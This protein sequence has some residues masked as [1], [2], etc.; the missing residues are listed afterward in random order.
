MTEAPHGSVG[1]QPPAAPAPPPRTRGSPDFW[2]RV[3]RA[4]ESG[5]AAAQASAGDLETAR[6]SFQAELAQNYFQLRMLDARKRLIDD[7][8]AALATALQLTRN[9][10]ASGVASR[11]DVVQA[12][13][14]LKTTQA[15]AVDVGVARAQTEHAI[16][17]LIGA[18]ASAFSLPPVPL[19]AAPPPVP[20][21]RTPRSASPSPPTTRR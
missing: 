5:P 12:E 2:G 16:A 10:Y 17:L 1:G 11:V 19:A 18:P 4:V 3:R 13:T 20:V 15:L 9:R 21:G 6:L 7:T 8:G 14:Q